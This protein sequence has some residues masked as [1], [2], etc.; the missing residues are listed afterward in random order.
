MAREKNFNVG[1][2]QKLQFND[3]FFNTTMKGI[4]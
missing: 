3:Q 1:L 4:S 2:P